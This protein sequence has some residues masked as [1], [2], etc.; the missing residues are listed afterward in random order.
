MLSPRCDSRRNAT[1]RFER[2]LLL[3]G[4]TGCC[5]FG[6]PFRMCFDGFRI[7]TRCHVV[8]RHTGGGR[9]R[10]Q[11][12]MR[13]DQCFNGSGM[14]LLDGPHQCRRP[15][16][17]FFRVHFGAGFKQPPDRIGISIAR[18]Q[19]HHRFAGRPF[20]LRVCAGLQE[21]LDDHGIAVKAG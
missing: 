5:G 19:H 21:M 6:L 3:I 20:L 15:S 1:G 9:L 18:R 14:F 8:S 2:E 12:R 13:F 10:G 16:N 17:R 4:S 7:D 11:I